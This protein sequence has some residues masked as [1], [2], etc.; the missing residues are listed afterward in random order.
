MCI[1]YIL[2]CEDK[3]YYIGKTNN[4]IDRIESHFSNRGS[5]WTK[6]YKPIQVLKK[7]NNC[8]NYDEDKYTIKMMSKYGIENVR[9]G[10]FTS[11]ILSENEINILNKMI[12]GNKDVCYNCGKDS[13]FIMNCNQPKFSDEM[14][15]LHDNIINLCAELEDN[16]EIPL[17]TYICALQVVDSQIF[18]KFSKKDLSRI[19]GHEIDNTINYRNITMQIIL[20]IISLEEVL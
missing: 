17:E 20:H 12:R 11:V 4:E 16:V 1:I 18:E 15:T 5:Y 7:Y 3:K 10:S 8:D 14:R 9:G 13:H 19:M 6:K 2:E